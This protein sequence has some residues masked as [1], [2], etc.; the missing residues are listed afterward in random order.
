M[1]L[2]LETAQRHRISHLRRNKSALPRERGIYGLFFDVPPGVAPADGCYERDGL[3][4]LYV[5]TAGAD[6]SKNGHLRSR[7]GNNHLG[8]NERRSTVCQTLAALLPDLAGQCVAKLERDKPKFHTSDEGA[9]KLR[10][11]MDEHV[12]VCWTADPDPG[13]VEKQLIARYALPL[14][15]EHN[16]AHPFAPELEKLRASRRVAATPPASNVKAQL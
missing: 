13:K 3:Y 9:A 8:G 1:T 11:W 4:L 7:L 15:L 10:A 14:N 6:L 12:S 16:S 5:G 2:F